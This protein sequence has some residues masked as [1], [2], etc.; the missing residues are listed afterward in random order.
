[1]KLRGLVISRF[2]KQIYNGLSP[3]FNIHVSVS[4]LYITTIGQRYMNVVIVVIGNE[5]SQFHFWE[6]MFR[7]FVI[8]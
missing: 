8:V 5:A 2:P 6:Y 3:N 7:I 4:T 1:M